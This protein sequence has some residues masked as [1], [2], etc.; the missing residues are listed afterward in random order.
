M[1]PIKTL[2]LLFFCMAAA[3]T[4]CKKNKTTPVSS[5]FDQI[6]LADI[7]A[8][9]VEFND[10]TNT[11]AI[12]YNDPT[13]NRTFKTGSILFLRNQNPTLHYAKL[14]ILSASVTHLVFN[15]SAYTDAGVEFI[16]KKQVTIQ[17]D[18]D[19]FS[20]WSGE[21]DVDAGSCS[22]FLRSNPKIFINSNNVDLIVVNP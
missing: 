6:T 2:I 22:I 5:T 4:G 14:E 10:P 12:Y 18:F 19:D 3:S 13:E 8:Q 16:S 15:Y 11:G 7:K 21:H 17:A 9:T 1:K 20:S